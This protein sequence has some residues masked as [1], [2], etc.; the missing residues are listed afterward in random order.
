MIAADPG[1][2]F[3]PNRPLHRKEAYQILNMY[4]QLLPP[5]PSQG[6]YAKLKTVRARRTAQNCRVWI[7][8]FLQSFQQRWKGSLVNMTRSRSL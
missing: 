6:P 1:V 3:T 4:L 8:A 7:K 2:E 5:D